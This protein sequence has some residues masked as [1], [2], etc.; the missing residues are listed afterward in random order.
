VVDPRCLLFGQ[1]RHGV[2]ATNSLT[3]GQPVQYRF[4]RRH[5]DALARLLEEACR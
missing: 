2:A 4:D 1:N 5:Y 3:A